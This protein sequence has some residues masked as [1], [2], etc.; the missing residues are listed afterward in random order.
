MNFDLY[1]IFIVL[2][3]VPDWFHIYRDWH[4]DASIHMRIAHIQ[5]QGSI[6]HC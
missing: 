4:T 2:M 1:E 6:I 5:T 3:I